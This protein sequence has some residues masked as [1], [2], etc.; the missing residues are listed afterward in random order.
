MVN[1]GINTALFV[2]LS[3]GLVLW[4]FLLLA[5]FIL[6]IAES[7]NAD[8]SFKEGLIFWVIQVAPILIL[9]QVCSFVLRGIL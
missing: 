9:S 3:A 5:S 6:G 7:R 1:V 8:G 2:L 4:I